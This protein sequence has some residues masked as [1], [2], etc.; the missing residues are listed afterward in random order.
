MIY[1]QKRSVYNNF[2]LSREN[3]MQLWMNW[4]YYNCNLFVTQHSLCRNM[5]MLCLGTRY[6]T[7]CEAGNLDPWI[8]ALMLYWTV[9]MAMT[10]NLKDPWFSQICWYLLWTLIRKSIRYFEQILNDNGTKK[11][12]NFRNVVQNQKKSILSV[13]TLEEIEEVQFKKHW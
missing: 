4:K 5:F 7:N 13:F 9:V 8:L 6:A 1:V 12:L 3:S 10:S 11:K 2:N